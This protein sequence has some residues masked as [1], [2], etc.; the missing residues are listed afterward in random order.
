MT[1]IEW[2]DLTENPIYLKSPD[3]K[4]AGHWC[5][6][7]SAGCLNCYAETINLGNRFD[8]ASGLP[9][10]GSAPDNL[11]FDRS[12]SAKWANARKPKR[13]FICSMTDVFGEWVPREWQFALLDDAAKA[14]NQAI[15]LLTKRPTIALLTLRE[16]RKARNLN[17]LQNLWIGASIENA[18][19]LEDR[20]AALWMISQEGWSTF[21]SVEPLLER[22]D[23]CLNDW[24]VDWVIV[25]GESGS[26][27]RTS[28]VLNI[29]SIVDQC[30]ASRIRVFVKQL[31]SNVI[32]LP[33]YCGNN[34]KGKGKM[35]KPHEWPAYLRYRQH[36]FYGISELDERLG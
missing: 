34:G 22:V 1:G 25:G 30:K 10:S 32:D 23:L 2:T 4:M 17:A 3:G 14:P 28:S 6:K 29:K 18:L 15:Q 8:F 19:V 36:P 26:G 12:F 33:L 20:A 5:A 31:G 21:Y 11:I 13:R 7:K 35:A 9:Y 24:P 27:A 16:W